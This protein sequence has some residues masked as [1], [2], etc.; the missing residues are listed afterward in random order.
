[1]RDQVASSTRRH[2]HPHLGTVLLLLLSAQPGLLAQ[3]LNMPPVT[4]KPGEQVAIEISFKSPPA[5]EISALQWDTSIP[6]SQ[7][8]FQEEGT[9]LGPRARADGKSISCAP[10]NETTPDTKT[11]ACILY[12]GQQPI[13]DGVI[14]ILRLGVL[15]DTAAGTVKVRLENGLAVSKDLKRFPIGPVETVIRVRK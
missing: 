6:S 8:R 2:C 7:L 14:A 4:A 5:Q 12:G 13:G 3:T 11:S 9:S 10:K 15:P 1:M